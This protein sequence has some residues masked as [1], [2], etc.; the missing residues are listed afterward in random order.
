MRHNPYRARQIN[1]NTWVVDIGAIC[2][3]YLLV[4]EEKALVI[5]TGMNPANLR[6]FYET[7]T[8]LPMEVVNTHG[9][10][11]HTLCNGYFDKVF[12]HPMAIV[13]ANGGD[14]HKGNDRIPAEVPNFEP[15]PVNEGYV[16][17]LGGRHVEVLETPCHS[18]GDLM[19]LDRENRLLFTGDNLEV[20]QVLIY[21]GNGDIGATV[22]NHLD[23]MKK[24]EARY[25][26]YDYI[27]PAHN[28]SPIDKS[29][30]KYFIE[31]D[32]AI[33]GGAEGT[34]DLDSPSFSTKGFGLDEERTKYLRC[35][36]HKGL[37]LVYDIRKIHESKGLWGINSGNM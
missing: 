22:K 9:H 28:G 33:L 6:E 27:C 37:S 5:D 1:K 30:V 3:S 2:Y 34:S 4:G 20:G 19:F 7:I 26:E 14:V 36:E 16:F 23:I 31:A 12:M 10:G 15:I 24:I 29:Y 18:P 8:D 32:E 13:D 21:Y 11:D 25:D 35:Y 17:D